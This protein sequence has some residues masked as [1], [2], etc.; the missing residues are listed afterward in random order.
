MEERTPAILLLADGT[1]FY[2][3]STGKKGTTTGEIAFNTGMTGY[4]EVFTDPS[5]FGQI[6]IMN[7]P[8]IGNYGVHADENESDGIKISG[9]ITKKFSEVFSRISAFGSLEEMLERDSCV[10]ITDVDTR[11]LVRHVRNRGAMNALI[12]TDVEKL[13]ELREILAK[14]PSMDGQE[15]SSKVA[16]K[17]AYEEI[18]KESKFKVALL[19]F[20]V[21]KN[22]VRCL[23]DRNCHV[24]VFPLDASLEEILEFNPDGFMLSNGPGDPS[25][26]SD[27]ISLV[28]K[29]VETGKPIFGICLGHQILALSQ[30][31]RTEKM[32]NGHRGIN[33]PIKNL[34]TG[35]GEITSQNHGFVIS[36]DSVNE[37]PEMEVTH[38]HLNDDTIAGIAIKNKPVFSVQYHPE[39]SAGPHD[40]RYLFDQFIDNLANSKN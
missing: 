23:V 15:L 38:I 33:H 18:P 19:D 22:I 30:G 1:T 5:Y 7:S 35:K 37:N 26:M 17:V 40:S 34:I 13:E 4:Q 11:S 6:L 32:F 24:K 2:G 27:S 29:I 12:S 16:T 8:H 3:K 31:L 28:S 14:V 21:K 9:L 36:K 10:G 20:G 39:A 25:V